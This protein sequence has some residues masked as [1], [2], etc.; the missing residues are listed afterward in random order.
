MSVFQRV[1]EVKAS[2]V[3]VAAFHDDARSLTA[4]TPPPVRVKI[5]QFDAPVRAGSKVI[6]KLMLG[7]LGVTWDGEIDQY[8]PQQF[9]RDILHHGPFGK[10]QH[11]HSFS[12]TVGGTQ[13]T[14]RVIYEAP[15]GLLGR[16]LD[17]I[18]VR[19]SLRYLFFYRA[20]QTRRL[21][22]KKVVVKQVKPAARGW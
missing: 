10:W 8:A 16:L 14:D 17:P 11:T 2:L 19:P 13:V 3:D 21:L 9:F 6:F 4:I 1:F 12:A 22:E 5:V 18:L 20:R 15:F 7:P